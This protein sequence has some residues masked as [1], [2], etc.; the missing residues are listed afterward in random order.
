MKKNILISILVSSCIITSAFSQLS[1][2]NGVVTDSSTTLQWQDD[3]SNNENLI[4]ITT[5][6][7]AISYCEDLALDDKNDW[8]LPNK[9]ELLSLVD[10][11][12]VSPAIIGDI[13]EN[14]SS[15]YYWSSTTYASGTSNAWYVAFY[16][17]YTYYNDKTGTVYVRCVRAG[18]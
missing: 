17:G 4:K 5:W 10:Y 2:S 18:Q 11:S 8:R 1:K 16:T 13:F 3:Y 9:N 7:E 14:T 12:K 6:S 15:D